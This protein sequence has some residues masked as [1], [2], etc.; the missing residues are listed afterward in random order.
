MIPCLNRAT[1]G[2]G[3]LEAFLDA[4]AGAGFP[5]VEMGIEP[6]VE[7]ADKQGVPAA[8]EL[9][10]RR[11]LKLGAFFASP[12]WRNSDEEF[13]KTFAGFQKHIEIANRLGVVRCVTWVP[14]WSDLPYEQR[15]K[16]VV[17]R[18]AKIHQALRAG[19]I[20]FGIEPLG[21]K[22]LR[23]G[24]HD[25]IHTMKQ[26]LALSTAIGSGCG[27]LVDIWHWH[28][29]GGTIEEIATMPVE[30]I[31]D[32]HLNDAPDKP[33]DEQIDGERLLPGVGIIDTKGFLST[34]KRIGYRGPLAIEVFNAELKKLPLGEAAKQSKAA[35]DK[36]LAAA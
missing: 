4:A 26:G 35:I 28:T 14:S 17:P 7:V 27:L 8:V 29:G 12:Q 20:G 13:T 32:V 2:E 16:Q 22:T 19:G 31:V 15:W 21:P 6:F 24:P 10:A 5:M 30:A 36:V 11:N 34:L 1:V 33:R 23:K 25:F 18:L 3:T 9:L